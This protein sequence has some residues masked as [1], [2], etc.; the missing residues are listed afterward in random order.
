[1]S[2]ACL[3]GSD[4]LLDRGSDGWSVF[5]VLLFPCLGRGTVRHLFVSQACSLSAVVNHKP[6]FAVVIAPPNFPF[7]GLVLRTCAQPVSVRV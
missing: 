1:M 5:V 7:L 2:H 4:W 6:T 3:S